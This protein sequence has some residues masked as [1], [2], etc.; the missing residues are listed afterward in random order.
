MSAKLEAQ[1]SVS[2]RRPINE[3]LQHVIFYI[4]KQGIQRCLKIGLKRLWTGRVGQW[5]WLYLA[6][7]TDIAPPNQ[8]PSDLELVRYSD[9]REAS[10][11]LLSSLCKYKS[12]RGASIFLSRWFSRGA[13]LWVSKVADDLVGLQ[14]SLEGGIN[15]FYSLPIQ[16]REV[17]IVAVEV[18]PPFKGK[19]LYPRML[20]QLFL[21]LKGSGHRRAYIKVANSNRPM[22]R[23]MS[24][25]VC[26]RIGRVY[27]F[28]VLS[29]WL[30]IWDKI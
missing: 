13:T 30:T 2:Q 16:A 5:E 12:R 10:A 7:L 27:T 14:W 20:S 19:G 9:E 22:Q 17:I 28:K 24:K 6:D 4:R 3:Y 29:R 11:A 25:T 26:R 1:H 21:Q 15:G 8:N 23:S 18:F